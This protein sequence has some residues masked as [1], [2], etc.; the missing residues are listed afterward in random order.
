VEKKGGGGPKK[1][2][3]KRFNPMGGVDYCPRKQHEPP[4]GK[5]KNLPKNAGK[6]VST[7][8]GSYT[9]NPMFGGG[10]KWENDANKTAGRCSSRPV[11]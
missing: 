11:P 1:T 4:K 7:C 6:G 10:Q 8:Q 9:R 5:P 3:R 2:T